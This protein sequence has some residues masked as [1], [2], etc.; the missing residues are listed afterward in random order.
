MK[1]R[2]TDKDQGRGKLALFSKLVFNGLV[3]FFPG[4]KNAS[5]TSSICWELS[6]VEELKD[7]IIYI[8]RGGTLPPELH[9]SLLIAPLW[10]L[11]PLPSLIR[12]CLNLPFRTQGRSW[13][14]K[15]IL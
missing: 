3:S 8:P 2:A 10:S 14:L 1:N 12:N 9:Y 4:I 15:F 7:I 6:S 11:H 13:R 5:L